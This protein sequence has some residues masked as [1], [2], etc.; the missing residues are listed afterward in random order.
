[1]SIEPQATPSVDPQRAFQ[2]GLGAVSPMWPAY[3]VAAG[4]GL[5]YWWWNRLARGEHLD[6]LVEAASFAPAA[7]EPPLPAPAAFPPVIEET[8]D[9]VA[10]APS[11][12]AETVAAPVEAVIET[13]AE[14]APVVEAAA[15]PVLEAVEPV[16]EPVAA[17]PIVA[18]FVEAPT[19]IPAVASEAKP[20]VS[21]LDQSL[22]AWAATTPKI[23][24]KPVPAAPPPK[25]ALKAAPKK[26]ATKA[27]AKPKVAA[28]AAKKS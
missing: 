11:A 18:E 17:A 28:K 12:V 25:P 15:E 13:V 23:A 1:M 19:P 26:A 24:A 7:A 6:L 10:E 14:A 21:R 4:A 22:A 9:A 2:L 27:G 16:V 8:V 3:T 5:A 20:V